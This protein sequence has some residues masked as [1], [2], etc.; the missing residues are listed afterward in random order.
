MAVPFTNHGIPK[1]DG[2][3]VFLD[4]WTCFHDADY[5]FSGLLGSLGSFWDSLKIEFR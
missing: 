2:Y 3:T 1:Q 4:Q 5:I